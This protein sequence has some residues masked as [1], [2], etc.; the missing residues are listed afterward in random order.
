M[1]VLPV[2]NNCDKVKFTLSFKQIMTSIENQLKIESLRQGYFHEKF[3]N[4]F[5]K[6]V[7]SN[8]DLCKLWSKINEVR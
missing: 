5:R 8:L 1:L 4:K 2:K 6:I 3:S 7:F